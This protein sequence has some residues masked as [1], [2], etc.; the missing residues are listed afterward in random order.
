MFLR[1]IR[2]I[3]SKGIRDKLRFAVK[4]NQ[5]DIPRTHKRASAD[6]QFDMLKRLRFKYATNILLKELNLHARKDVRIG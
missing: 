6:I 3:K 4:F 1:Y 5:A 2:L